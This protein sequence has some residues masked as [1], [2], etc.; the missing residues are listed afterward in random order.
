MFNT[1]FFTWQVLPKMV[2]HQDLPE[3]PACPDQRTT[4]RQNP[5][6]SQ[7]L[8]IINTQVHYIDKQIGNHEICHTKESQ[9][10]ITPPLVCR[11]IQCLIPNSL[12]LSVNHVFTHTE[13]KRERERE[14]LTI[15]CRSYLPLGE[16]VY[17]YKRLL[18]KIPV[19]RKHRERKIYMPDYWLDWMQTDA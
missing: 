7:R 1:F 5:M 2:S 15:Q 16:W 14:L 3:H 19:F 6:T 9:L 8:L 18:L 4:I 17:M 11:S 10:R 12:S 13:W